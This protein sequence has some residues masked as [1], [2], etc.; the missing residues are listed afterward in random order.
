MNEFWFVGSMTTF[1]IEFFYLKTLT[2]PNIVMEV[3]ESKS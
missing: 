1:G 3:V 2:I